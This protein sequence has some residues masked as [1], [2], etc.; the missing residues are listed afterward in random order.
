MAVPGLTELA[1]V[2]G[3]KEIPRAV[4][5]RHDVDNVGRR[6]PWLDQNLPDHGEALVGMA[7]PA[8]IPLVILWQGTAE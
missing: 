1:H 5:T 4:R 7:V 8:V 2:R 3:G 6:P